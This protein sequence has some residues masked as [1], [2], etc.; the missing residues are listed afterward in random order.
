MKKIISIIMCF[1]MI[2]SLTM[3]AFA[4]TPENTINIT[5]YT[6]EDIKALE[7]YVYIENGHF[8]LDVEAAFKDG[9]DINLL[10][11]Q[12]NYF[13]FLNEKADNNLIEINNDL[14]I[15]N[16]ESSGPIASPMAAHWASCGGGKCTEA[17]THWW[18]FS[19]YLCDCLTRELAADIETA[20]SVTTAIGVIG[21]IFGGAVAVPG[22]LGTAYF[23]LLGSRMNA[24]NHGRGILMEMTWVFAFDIT[25]Q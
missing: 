10:I 16:I 18:G 11:G 23:I 20:S 19:R 22:G 3:V 24:N 17:T 2:S 12:Q 8:A 5:D 21:G 25:P 15:T 9:F 7:P 13:D 14:S 1:V 4:Q 6:I